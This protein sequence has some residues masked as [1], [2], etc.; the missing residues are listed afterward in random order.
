MYRIKDGFPLADLILCFVS[1][2]HRLVR[3]V[4]CRFDVAIWIWFA[5]GSE[6]YVKGVVTADCQ[7]VDN[8]KVFILIMKF[9]WL[10]KQ[11]GFLCKSSNNKQSKLRRNSI[12]LHI[13][14]NYVSQMHW[15]HRY[16]FGKSDFNFDLNILIT[17]VYRNFVCRILKKFAPLLS[18][19]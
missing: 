11:R 14:E 2:C 5:G 3:V 18:K 19:K 10:L 6:V 13:H 12:L 9:Y 4:L 16:N 15:R 17:G 7:H 1:L 8:I